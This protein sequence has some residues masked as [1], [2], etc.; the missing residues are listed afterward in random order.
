M[1]GKSELSNLHTKVVD[2]CKAR[3]SLA[4]L[5]SLR[6]ARDAREENIEDRTRSPYSVGYWIAS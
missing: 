3:A 5:V 1:G 6:D 2:E 4:S